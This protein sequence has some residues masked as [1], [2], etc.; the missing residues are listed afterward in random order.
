MQQAQ[1]QKQIGETKMNK[2]S[3][4]SHCVF[5]IRVQGK[6]IDNDGIIEF[7]GKLHLVDLAGSECAKSTGLE[8]SS[9]E[10]NIT[11]N[12]DTSPFAPI[13]NLFF[14]P[15]SRMMLLVRGKE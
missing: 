4:R 3:S 14:F 5:T 6:T 9:T 1:N 8:H 10:V 13:L 7:D 15:L 2:Q 11:R 12:N